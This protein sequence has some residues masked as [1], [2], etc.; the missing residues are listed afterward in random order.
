MKFNFSCLACVAG[1]LLGARLQAQPPAPSPSEAP[2]EVRVAAS[3]AP[4]AQKAAAD[5]VCTG[6]NDERVINAAIRRLEHGGT[7]RLSDGDYYV[8]AFEQEGNSAINFG[9]NDGRARVTSIVGTTEN[10]AYNTAYGATIHVTERAMSGMGTGPHDRYR[11]FYGCARKPPAPGAF[12]TYTHVNNANFA[13]FYVKFHDASKPVIAF[14][15]RLFGSMSLKLI[16]VYT[17]KYFRNRFLHEPVETPHVNSVGVYSVPSS[18]DEQARIRYDTCSVGGLHTGFVAEGVDH[19]IMQTCTAARCVVGYVFR[20]DCWKTLTMLNCADEGNAMLPQFYGRGHLTCIDFCIER[21]NEA[22]IPRPPAGEDLVLGAFEEDDGAW[23]GF[24]SYTFQ[25]EGYGVM[26]ERVGFWAKGSGRNFRTVDLNADLDAPAVRRPRD[27]EAD[28]VI[29][30][31]TSAGIAAAVAARRRGLSSIVVEPSRRIGGLTTGGLGQTDIGNKSAFGGIAREFYK[32]VKRYYDDDIHWRFQRRGDY[33]ATGQAA[34]QTKGE[35]DTMWTFEPSAALRILRRWVARDEICVEFGE[36]LDRTPAGGAAKGRAEGVVMDA[37]RIVALRTESGRT[38]RGKVFIDATY[39]GDLMAAAGVSYVV[40]R[41]SNSAYG[42]TLNGCQPSIPSAEHHQVKKGVSAYV[43]AGDRSSGL[44]PGVEPGPV[45]PP[46]AGDRRVQAY[47]FRSC[48]TDNPK[49]RIPFAKPEGYDERDYELLLRN[50]EAGEDWHVMG[51]CPLPN[52]KTDTNNNRGTSLDFIG[53]NWDYPEASYEERDRIV[54]AHLKYQK[55]L[56]WT[57]A[58]HPRVPESVRR[59]CSRWGTC[60]DEFADGFGDGWQRQLY[61]REARR[62]VGDYVMTEANCT[63]ERTASRPVALAA[64]TMDSHHVRRYATPDGFVRNEGNV[65]EDVKRGPYPIDYGAIVP[66]RSE[67]ANLL[68]PV[69]LSASHIAY[70][71]IRME[72][73]FFSLGEVAARAAAEAVAGGVSVQDVDWRRAAVDVPG[74]Q[75][76]SKEQP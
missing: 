22:Y 43:V 34:R 46:G 50:L 68:V 7:V 39:E 8:D 44:L 75:L 32:A 72:P 29:Y 24:I 4:A 42:E 45:D 16:G 74:L 19:L 49:N 63:G 35:A 53:A 15:G 27:A 66:K 2:R 6:T 65:E 14:D 56:F 59:E 10:K 33:S 1:A 71:S 37:G 13:N 20:G 62:M 60:R 5:M 38:F 47:C 26:R 73:V 31:G 9:Y 17:E 67:C 28:V 3:N 36:R 25:G 58:N 23:R 11:L 52:R 55:G 69:C 41:E 48:L 64:Y 61:V 57:L 12:F 54:A 40:G 21:F 70:G 51:N 30:G 18:N 76:K